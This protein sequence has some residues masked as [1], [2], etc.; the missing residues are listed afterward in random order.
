MQSSGNAW[1]VTMFPPISP[2]LKAIAI[3]VHHP[4]DATH[5]EYVIYTKEDLAMPASN[6]DWKVIQPFPTLMI[7]SMSTQPYTK[8]SPSAD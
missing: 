4:L 7:T 6:K 2:S 8:P 1:D 5:K 3:L